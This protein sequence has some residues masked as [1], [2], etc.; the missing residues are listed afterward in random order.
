MSAFL[1]F[2]NDNIQKQRYVLFKSIDK[3]S[4]LISIVKSSFP[5]YHPYKGLGRILVS[6]QEAIAQAKILLAEHMEISVSSFDDDY[7]EHFISCFDTDD[8]KSDFSLVEL[9]KFEIKK[10]DIFLSLLLDKGILVN[11]SFS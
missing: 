5:S 7:P 4:E 2:E 11:Y 10:L 6:S 9:G 8:K 3:N 1:E